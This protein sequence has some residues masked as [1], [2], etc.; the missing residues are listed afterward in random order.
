MDPF[1][2]PGTLYTVESTAADQGFLD[3][4]IYPGSSVTVREFLF[5]TPEE[6]AISIPAPADIRSPTSL[7]LYA[8][9]N[10]FPETFDSLPPG[11]KDLLGA[12]FDFGN[13][14]DAKAS[15]SEGLQSSAGG[16]SLVFP[17]WLAD[18]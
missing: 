5:G 3:V 12:I 18:P 14:D 7:P 4:P 1:T 13:S 11:A 15:K 10:L 6:K 2:P 16:N 9:R 17:Q 8:F